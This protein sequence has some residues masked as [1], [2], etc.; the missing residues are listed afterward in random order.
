MCRR[1]AELAINALT[2]IRGQLA[3]TGPV[4]VVK[5][6]LLFAPTGLLHEISM[7]NDW[8]HQFVELARDID[9]LLTE[10]K[11]QA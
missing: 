10:L 8:G 9:L 11:D 7:D 6:R 5:A 3:V 1:L 4:D 2:H